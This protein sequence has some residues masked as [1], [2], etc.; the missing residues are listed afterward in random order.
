MFNLSTQLKVTMMAALL[1]WGTQALSSE[2]AIVIH[3][4]AGTILKEKM[5][6]A[7]EADYRRVLQKSVEAGHRVLKSGGSSIDAVTD[8]IKIMENSPLFNAGH[9]ATFN[10]DGKVELDASIMTGDK[11]NAGAVTGIQTVRNPILLAL[12]ILKNSPHVM[13]MGKGAEAFAKHQ[14]LEI[15]ENDYFYT[16]RRRNQLI[17]AQSEKNCTN[18]SESPDDDFE[19]QIFSTVGAVAIDSGGLIT[20][21][22]STGGM[23]NKRYGR[24]GDSPVIGAGTYADSRHCGISAT[25][26]GEYFIRAAIAHDICARVNY[27]GITLQSAADEVI[28]DKLKAMGGDGGVIGIDSKANIIYSFNTP[29]MYRAKIDKTGKR[30]V[31]IFR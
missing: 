27:K 12:A 24:I 26:H 25:G 9:G 23:T 16:E 7:I 1:V 22:T 3:G 28:L 29:G 14:G 13:L 15:V 19:S 5:S 6:Q 2:I 4:G 18:L 8:A 30:E 31:A 11:L 21:G 17:K 10:Y 20:A